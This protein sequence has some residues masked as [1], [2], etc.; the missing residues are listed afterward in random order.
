MEI[1]ANFVYKGKSYKYSRPKCSLDRNYA[2]EGYAYFVEPMENSENGFFEIN[3]LKTK[4]VGGELVE[5]GYAAVYSST[6]Q[7]C[8]DI[9]VDAIIHFY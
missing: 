3:I 8:P 5:D 2:D 9:L 1:Q 7:I 4:E 6:N